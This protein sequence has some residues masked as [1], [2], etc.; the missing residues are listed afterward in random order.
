MTTQL[1]SIPLW[2]A[3]AP[4][5]AGSPADVHPMLTPYLP[6]STAPVG[7]IVVCPCGGY[8]MRAEHEGEPIALWLNTLGL[9]AFV[10]SYR[11]APHRHPIPL[12]DA[13]RAIRTVR[14]RAAEWNVRPDLVGII[15]FS[16]GG[17]LAATAATQWDCGDPASDDPLSRASC[18]PDLAIL[19]YPVISM[20]NAQH[21]GSMTNLLGELPSLDDRRAQSAD[22]NVT[23]ETPPAFLWH[24]ADDAS[25]D[26]ENSLA[27]ASALRRNGV[28]FAL[29]VFPTGPHGLGLAPD[30]PEA[31]AW[32]DLCAQFLQG[33][34]WI[35]DD[36]G[37]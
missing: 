4:E 6:E 25:V 11:V 3:G 30:H 32:P 12:G 31:R 27:F 22:L 16:A 23:R 28:P 20:F 37:R 2:T 10:V 15:G 9:A 17:H 26:V 35:D 24:T 1:E 21:M 36:Q 5:L 34:G 33:Q 18:R 19:C 8:Q 14:A 13:Q 7:A 29:H